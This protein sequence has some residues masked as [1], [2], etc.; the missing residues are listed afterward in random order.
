MSDN[1]ED[2]I[3]SVMGSQD[4]Q[5]DAEVGQDEG[6]DSQESSTQDWE[7]QAKYQQSEKDKLYA[8]N[9]QLKQYDKVGKFLE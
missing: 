2:V 8:E 6:T 4:G 9:Q 7:A 5:P 1:N 3:A